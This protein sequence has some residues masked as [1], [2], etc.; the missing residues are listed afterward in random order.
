M[1]LIFT[2]NQKRK[3]DLGVFLS[4]LLDSN[5]SRKSDGQKESTFMAPNFGI[6][7]GMKRNVSLRK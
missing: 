3:K 2:R 4:V 7:E 6:K 5:A 1:P